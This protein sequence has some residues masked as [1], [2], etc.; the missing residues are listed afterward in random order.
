MF[1]LGL[2]TNNLVRPHD[3]SALCKWGAVLRPQRGENREAL[4]RERS[5]TRRVPANSL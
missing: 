3:W 4:S 1:E 5:P 2:T